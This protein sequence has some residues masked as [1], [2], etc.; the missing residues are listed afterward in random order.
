MG[1]DPSKKATNVIQNN[2]NA[3]TIFNS[4]DGGVVS[5]DKE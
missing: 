3:F 4:V 2:Q 5:C 1:A